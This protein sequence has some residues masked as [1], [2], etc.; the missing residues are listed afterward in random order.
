VRANRYFNVG[1]GQLAVFVEVINLYNRANVRS[2]EYDLEVQPGGQFVS[3]RL[4]EKWLP[5]L[6]SL[7][8]SW[9]F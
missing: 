4:V 7:G 8:I 9:E 1:K 2:Y 5:R 6:P 3:T